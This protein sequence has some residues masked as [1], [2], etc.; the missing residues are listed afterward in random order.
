MTTTNTTA[1]THIERFMNNASTAR[2]LWTRGF[3]VTYQALRAGKLL[4]APKQAL[5][6]K[7]YQSALMQY[8]M[9]KPIGLLMTDQELRS[10][11]IESRGC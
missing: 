10:L 6:F 2:I 11:T 4:A 9:D 1:Q 5:L 3:V 7:G 8:A